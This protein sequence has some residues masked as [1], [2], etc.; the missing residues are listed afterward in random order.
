M[1]S[2]T[3]AGCGVAACT[4]ARPAYVQ[5]WSINAHQPGVYKLASS[6]V[7]SGE[8]FDVI[9]LTKKLHNMEIQTPRDFF[10]SFRFTIY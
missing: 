7:C 2:S 4:R 3:V 8:E 9:Y 6:V 10:P 1:H 5:N